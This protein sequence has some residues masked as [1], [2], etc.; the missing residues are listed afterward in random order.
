MQANKTPAIQS[1]GFCWDRI[2]GSKPN[3]LLGHFALTQKG[4]HTQQANTKQRQR[5]RFGYGV[6]IGT[7]DGI[8][9]RDGAK[10]VSCSAITNL[11]NPLRRI[12]ERVER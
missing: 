8:G 6:E 3:L 1:G 11:C 4:T 5:S 7:P 12:V 10:G 2:S 9:D